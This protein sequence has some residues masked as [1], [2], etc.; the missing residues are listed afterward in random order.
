MEENPEGRLGFAFLSVLRVSV[1]TF[2]S[3]E[4]FRAKSRTVI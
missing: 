4:G 1:V 3:S 2:H